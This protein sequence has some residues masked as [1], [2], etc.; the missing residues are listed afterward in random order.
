MSAGPLP[1][2]ELLFSKEDL[3][4]YTGLWI[5]KAEAHLPISTNHKAPWYESVTSQ[6][7]SW[8]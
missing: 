2:E 6:Q 5:V 4:T 7:E 8:T 1:P 3:S